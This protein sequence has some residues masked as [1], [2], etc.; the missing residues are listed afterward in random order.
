MRYRSLAG[1]ATLGLSASCVPPLSLGADTDTATRSASLL[2][3][4]GTRIG[5]MF[6]AATPIYPAPGGLTAETE[7]A[8]FVPAAQDA[9]DAGRA[10]D[11]LTAAVY[12]EARSQSLDGQRAV[13]QV[14]LNRVRSP[15]F[16]GSVCGVVYQ[17]SHLSTGCQF[18]F[19]CDG[20][21]LARREPS[22]WERAAA[23]ARDAL[24]GSVYAP[25]GTATFYHANYVSPWWAPSL[26]QVTT[27]G[28]HIFYRWPGTLGLASAFTRAYAGLEPLRDGG[29]G[30]N[31]VATMESVMRYTFDGTTIA[32]FRGNLGVPGGT[33]PQ[34]ADRSEGGVQLHFGDKDKTDA[35]PAADAPS[36]AAESANGVTV[37]HGAPPAELARAARGAI[38]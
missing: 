29:G 26:T 11:C 19:T 24:G 27:I 21:L 33:K 13:A 2:P 22:A 8:P 6:L 30:N 28:A 5:G 20:S 17:G 10:L 31:A 3:A 7:A 38:G 4:A 1:I 23:V 32:V 34:T 9:E 25:V 37:H 36:V 18:S 16:P 15:A 12:Y 35:A 14:V